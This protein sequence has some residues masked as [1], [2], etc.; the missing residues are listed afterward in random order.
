VKEAGI[1]AG[2]LAASVV[3]RVER[4]TRTGGKM[5]ILGLSDPTGHFEAVVFS[6]GLAQFRDLLEPGSAVLLQV[7]AEAQ[8][9]EV[10]VRIHNAESLDDA[11]AKSQRGL[12]VFLQSAEPIEL[13][14]K[15]LSGSANGRGEGTGEISFVLLL[16]NGAEVEVKLPGRYPVSP[17]IA[18]AMKAVPGVL[19]VEAL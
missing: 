6:E 7:G 12:R 15:R 4:R 17:Q 11:A 3:S 13:V 10:R 14:A 8:G 19:E 9:D 16:E 1:T 18:G 5:G 2:R